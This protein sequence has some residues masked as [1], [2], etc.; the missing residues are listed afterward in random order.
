MIW[1]FSYELY[2]R[3]KYISRNIDVSYLTSPLFTF[4]A[5]LR[6]SV[7]YFILVY[8]R[9]EPGLGIWVGLVW[10]M[11]MSRCPG[12][13]SLHPQPLCDIC[14]SLLGDHR[15]IRLSN[16]NEWKVKTLMKIEINLL[17]DDFLGYFFVIP[18]IVFL[19]I[20][21]YIKFNLFTLKWTWNFK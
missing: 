18:H 7:L 2:C 13:N 3:A 11:E 8:S 4:F 10:D 5:V 21:L 16:Q 12:I 6:C 20:N 14:R 19:C 1:Q 15:S 17:Y 9:Y